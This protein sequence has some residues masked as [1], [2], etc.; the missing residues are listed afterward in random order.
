MGNP[1]PLNFGM[2]I[3][4]IAKSQCLLSAAAPG[5]YTSTCFIEVISFSGTVDYLKFFGIIGKKFLDLGGIPHWP[6]QW[7][8]LEKC[9]NVD[10]RA[11]L[12]ERF[13]DNMSKFVSARE[14]LKVDETNLFLNTTMG[15]LLSPAVPIPKK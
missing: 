1:Y 10:M 5:D 13:G 8:F 6:K 7:A 12:W 11:I 15:H 3:R 14:A 4:F 9:D 2:D